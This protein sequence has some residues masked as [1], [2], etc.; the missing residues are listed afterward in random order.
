MN[1]PF[2][3]VSTLFFNCKRQKVLLRLSVYRDIEE[4]TL[5]PHEER[6]KTIGL[7]AGREF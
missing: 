5:G 2:G 3:L 6:L 1:L 4:A 7:F